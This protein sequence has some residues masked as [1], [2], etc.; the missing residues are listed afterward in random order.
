MDMPLSWAEF[1]SFWANWVLLGALTM[2]LV[3][4]FCIVESANVKEAHWQRE[5]LAANE[6]I[7]E[8]NN[9]TERLREAQLANAE[10][11]KTTA[12]TNLANRS[13][14]DA[15]I[16]AQG[17]AERETMSEATRSLY[18]SPKVE[19][20]AGKHFDAVATSRNLELVALLGSL[21]AVLNKSGWIEVEQSDIGSIELSS[22]GGA[23]LVKI[24]VDAS[25]DPTLLEAA[26][27]LASALNAEGIA[28]EINPN[29]T[30]TNVIHI[31]VGP[32]T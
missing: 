5:R 15:V 23:A 3:A 31:L 14:M 20:F 29:A 27:A 12:L 8:L 10:A 1:I 26:K 22:A 4:T 24:E 28:A 16:V 32:K 6:R 13:V 9:E 30:N 21:K 11:S 17:L 2:G 7:A 18:I 19:S 25:K